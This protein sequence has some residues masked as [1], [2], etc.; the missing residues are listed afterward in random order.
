MNVGRIAHRP[1]YFVPG[2]QAIDGTFLQ[3]S[4]DYENQF[5]STSAFSI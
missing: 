4:G 2:E 5:G 3:Y 1:A